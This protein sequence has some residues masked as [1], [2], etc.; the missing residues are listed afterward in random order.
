[1]KKILI[2][3]SQY[4]ELMENL[5]EVE[6]HLFDGFCMNLEKIKP[7]LDESGKVKF[8]KLYIDTDSTQKEILQA[9]KWLLIIR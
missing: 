4:N 6:Y 2:T 7:M 1:M 9:F 8:Y 5:E 3:K